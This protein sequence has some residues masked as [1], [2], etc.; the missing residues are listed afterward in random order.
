MTALVHVS[1]LK[2][3]FGGLTAVN[4][5]SFEVQEGEII[6]LLGPNGSG[7]TTVL[8]MISGALSPTSGTITLAGSTISGL[9]PHKIAHKGVA[10]TF[11]LV[12]ILPSLTVAENVIAALAFKPDPL[13]GHSARARAEE[14]LHQIGLAGRGDDYAN[15]LTYIDQKRMEL[16][17]ALAA[18]PRLLLLDEWLSG[19]NPTELRVGIELNVSLRESGMTIVLVEHIMEAVRALCTRA[20]VMNV[21]KKIAEGP[22]ADVLADPAVIAAY[23]GDA[24]A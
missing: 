6:A 8:N 23:L 3:Q 14:L 22:T 17:R 18:E 20:V 21:G 19:L 10:R 13:W 7:K 9:P 4:A 24:H 12:K 5:V 16:A 2:K 1:D 11:Q 15:D